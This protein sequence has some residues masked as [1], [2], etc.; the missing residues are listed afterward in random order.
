MPTGKDRDW[1]KEERT[2]TNIKNQYEELLPNTEK[3]STQI[4][5]TRGIIDGK[6]RIAPKK[7]TIGI[8]KEKIIVTSRSKIV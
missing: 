3:F 2:T 6:K 4:I 5:P 8:L 7:L 1:Q